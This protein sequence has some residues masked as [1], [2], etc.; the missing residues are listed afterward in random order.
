MPRFPKSLL[1]LALAVWPGLTAP[2]AAVTPVRTGPAVAAE[3]TMY[4][5][6]PPILVRAPRVTLEEILARVA[7]GERRRD[8]LMTDQSFLLTVRIVRNARKDKPEQL[9]METVSR[10]WKKKPDKARTELLR[11]WV[12]HP[13]KDKK[14]SVRVTMRGGAAMD[15]QIVNFA[16][17]PE[18]HRQ[19]RYRI[20]G[21]DLV[22]GDHLIY[23]IAFEPRSLLD[24]STPRGVVWVDTRDFV[25]LRQEVSFDRSPAAPILKGIDRMVIE[26]QNV[27]GYWVLAR[28]LLRAEAALPL[29]EVGRDFDF[30]L[31][32]DQ[33]TINTGLPDSLFTGHAEDKQ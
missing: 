5:E 10:V 28:V 19:F 31:R 29:P 16:F 30:A 6:L 17:R 3:D 27:D 12:E 7:R 25:I 18:A 32:F 24:P 8:S 14:G 11:R 33:Y 22:G 2:A 26:R 21:R 1:V 13:E 4:T 23:R 15:E 9:V 20:L